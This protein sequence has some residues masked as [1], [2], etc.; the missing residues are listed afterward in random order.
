MTMEFEI[1]TA[2]AFK[3]G[4]QGKYSYERCYY[5][6]STTCNNETN[7]YIHIRLS[8]DVQLNMIP[9]YLVPVSRHSAAA[10]MDVDGH[11]PPQ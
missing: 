9:L 8:I 2:A 1:T 3:E 5:L 10:V 11:M 6:M 7:M 4:P